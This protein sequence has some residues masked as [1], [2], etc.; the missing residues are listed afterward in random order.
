MAQGTWDGE[1]AWLSLLV[2]MGQEERGHAVW[3]DP[4][5]FKVVTAL[6]RG[7]IFMD[8]WSLISSK[9]RFIVILLLWLAPCVSVPGNM[10]AP[11]WIEHMGFFE[12]S[13]CHTVPSITDGPLKDNRFYQSPSSKTFW[14]IFSLSFSL[15]STLC[16]FVRRHR[17]HWENENKMEVFWELNTFLKYVAHRQ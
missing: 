12:R 14:C 4:T 13:H 10:V 2:G 3:D 8:E 5:L 17:N 16:S 6:G 11:V 9:K 15:L 7:R 1:A